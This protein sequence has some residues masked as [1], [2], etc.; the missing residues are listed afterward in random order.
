MNNNIENNMSN[1]KIIKD[2]PDISS[3][4]KTNQENN[5]FQSK[6]RQINNINFNFANFS[7]NVNNNDLNTNNTND[8]VSPVSISLLQKLSTKADKLIIEIINSFSLEKN[9]KIEINSLGMINGSK[10]NANDGITYFGLIDEE[11]E[12]LTMV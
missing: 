12:M 11:E 10:R 1:N 9:L 8:N 6:G 7:H 2:I 3:L 5:K 4:I